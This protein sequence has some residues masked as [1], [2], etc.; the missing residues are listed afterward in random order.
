MASCVKPWLV[1]LSLEPDLLY[2]CAGMETT[3]RGVERTLCIQ[4]RLT[5]EKSIS[6]NAFTGLAL[7]SLKARGDW[8][9]KEKGWIILCSL[10]ALLR[11]FEDFDRRYVV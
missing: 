7:V 5:A 4:V 9:R 2:V 1:T 8:H 6:A 10:F 3:L 11:Y